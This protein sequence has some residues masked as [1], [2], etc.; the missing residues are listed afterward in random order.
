MAA[1]A[2]Q[3][4]NV[5]VTRLYASPL[6]RARESAEIVGQALGLGYDIVAALREWDVGLF[7]GR[8]DEPAWEKYWLLRKS[9]LAGRRDD[10]IEGGESLA[11]IELRFVPFVRQLVASSKAEDVSLFIGHGGLYAAALPALLS[12][13]S[14]AFAD[15]HGLDNAS[16]IVAEERSGALRCST[17]GEHSFDLPGP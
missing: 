12:N 7:E 10:R 13:V 5:G 17:W 4:V 2:Q 9:W 3:L 14:P 1:L 11:D 6:L 8:R 15:S 16:F